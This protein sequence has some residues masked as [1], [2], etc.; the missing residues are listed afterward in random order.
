[1]E[2]IG[3]V[4][5]AITMPIVIARVI[6]EKSRPLAMGIWG[7]FIP[8]GIALSMLASQ[9]FPGQWRPLWWVTCIYALIALA[10]LLFYVVP[11]LKRQQ[12]DRPAAAQHDGLYTSV[13]S[14]DPLLLAASFMLYSMLFVTL[15]TFLPTVLSESSR[16]TVEQATTVSVYIVLCNIAG[17]LTGGWLI[18]RGVALKLVLMAAIV[19]AGLFA[20]LVFIDVLDLSLRVTSGL[21]ACYLGGMLPAAVFASI[22]TFVAPQKSGLLL[23][24][25]FQALACGQVAGPVTLAALVETTGSWQSGVVYFFLLALAG[26]IVLLRFQSRKKNE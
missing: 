12:H 5:L 10:V 23:G 8:G 21:L 2:G 13:F 15:V 11:S 7:T 9:F 3:Y 14:R 19:G 18:G 20:G 6:S 4:L 16:L 25:V 1:M 17:N 22:A 24:V 26:C